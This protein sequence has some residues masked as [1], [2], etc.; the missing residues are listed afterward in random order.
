MQT[1]I[2]DEVVVT[3]LAGELVLLHLGS[4]SYFGLDAVGT[5]IWH[6]IAQ[7]RSTEAVIPLLLQEF[8]VDEPQLRRDLDALV[9]QLLAQ[10]LLLAAD[11]PA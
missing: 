1:T 2:P 8:D 4:G 5:R 10:G 9:A 6:L 11:G 3:D 7:S